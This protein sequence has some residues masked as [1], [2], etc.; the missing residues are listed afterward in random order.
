[1]GEIGTNIPPTEEDMQWYLQQQEAG[2]KAAEKRERQ[3]YLRRWQRNIDR[4]TEVKLCEK[5]ILG[6]AAVLVVC[7]FAAAFVHSERVLGGV[8]I[9]FLIVLVA[10]LHHAGRLVS[11][12][13]ERR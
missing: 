5:W 4:Q 6:L 12:A 13:L 8:A 9:V 3:Q 1:M 10:L 7:F 11:L 2:E